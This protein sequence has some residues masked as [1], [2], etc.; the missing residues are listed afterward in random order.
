MT[1]GGSEENTKTTE[2]GTISYNVPK[3]RL[4]AAAVTPYQDGRLLISRQLPLRDV[5]ESEI[6]VFGRKFG[7]K[8]GYERFEAAAGHHDDVVMAVCFACWGATRLGGNVLDESFAFTY[9]DLVDSEGFEDGYDL[10]FS[11]W[12]L[13][14]S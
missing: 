10:D 5:L 12:Q 14:R 3:D 9:D 4:V 2:R 8:P 13:G 6:E 11:R 1:T 7:R